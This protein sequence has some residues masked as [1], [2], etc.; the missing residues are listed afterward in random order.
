MES[1]LV[2]KQNYLQKLD[3]VFIELKALGLDVESGKS[4]FPPTLMVASDDGELVSLN[5][6][7]AEAIVR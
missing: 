4:A 7:L 2:E 6:K 5:K 1:A 3:Q